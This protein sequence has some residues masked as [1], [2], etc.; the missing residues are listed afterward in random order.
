M[1]SSVLAGC[2]TDS[3][4]IWATHLLKNIFSFHITSSFIRNHEFTR[5]AYC[6]ISCGLCTSAWVTITHGSSCTADAGR[7]KHLFLSKTIS[8]CIIIITGTLYDAIQLRSMGL[9]WILHQSLVH[10][11]YDSGILLQNLRVRFILISRDTEWPFGVDSSNSTES[12][13]EASVSIAV[14]DSG[15][16]ND[17]V[18]VQRRQRTLRLP[19][20]PPPQRLHRVADN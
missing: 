8:I 15:L 4:T 6:G 5:Q 3:A 9:E 2:Q 7:I 18:S 12:V 11:C 10:R 19:R 17:N 20:L 14:K 1:L 16:F 13:L